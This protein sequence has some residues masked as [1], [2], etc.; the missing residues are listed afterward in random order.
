MKVT[1]TPAPRSTVR[2]EVEVPPER[3]ARAVDLAVR[4]LGQRTRV[5]GFRPGKVPRPMLERALGV[6]RGDPSAPNPIHDEAKDDLFEGTIGEALRTADVAALDIPRPEWLHFG[7]GEDGAA[8]A[9]ALPVSPTVKLGD[10]TAYPFQPEVEPVD[11]G[12]AT[13]VIDE[14]R[15]QHAAL[16][17]VEDRPAANDDYAV[18]AYE[19]TRDGQPF[20]GGS[21]ERVPL[22]LGKERMI[23][24]FEAQLVGLR[25]G[26]DKTFELTFPADYPDA[27]LAGQPASFHVTL[28]ELRTKVLPKADDEFARTVSDAANL[29]AMRADITAR[30]EA[31]ARDRARHGF[32]DRVIEYAVANATVEPPDLLVDREVEIMHDE[33]RLRL[34][35]QGIGYDEYLKVTEKDDAALHAQFRPDAEHRVKVLLVLEAIADEEHF[36]VPEA[37]VE[38]EVARNRERTGKDRKLAEYFASDRGRSYVRTTMRRSGIVEALVERWLAA[39]PEVGPLPHLEDGPAGPEAGAAIEPVPAEAR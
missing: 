17:P 4:H 35:E 29:A 5:P 36:E 13:K 2:L 14:L 26:E 38:A 24:G 8:Y 11:E 33:L 27:T 6:Q 25:E 20:E 34:A 3:V 10:Y 31:N 21:A 12:Q 1:A 23:P 7:E 16:V 37:A 28:R 39:H 19:A 9:L 18:I 15:D 32:A 22:V 30:L